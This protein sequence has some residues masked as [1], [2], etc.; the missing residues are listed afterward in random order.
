MKRVLV[1]LVL[2]VLL[3]L[4]GC[5]TILGTGDW[6]EV[7]VAYSGSTEGDYSLVVTPT[8]VSYTL[9]GK[10][11]THELP[12][13]AWTAL[14]TGVRAL[15]SHT[16]GNCADGSAITIQASAAGTVK[17]TFEASSCDAD[18]VFATAKQLVEQVVSQLK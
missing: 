7:K 10:A 1:L 16:A 12:A 2:P 14:T 11:S 4:S 3:V 17:Q 8:E 6:D 13:G 9:D 15:G 18:G 5:S